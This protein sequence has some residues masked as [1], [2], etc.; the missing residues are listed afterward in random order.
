MVLDSLAFLEELLFLEP[1]RWVKEDLL[2]MRL[3]WLA[4]AIRKEGFILENSD[5]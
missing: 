1:L 3:V 4:W 5:F 2:L